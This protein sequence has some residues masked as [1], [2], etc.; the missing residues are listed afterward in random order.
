MHSMGQKTVTSSRKRAQERAQHAA[1]WVAAYS[2]ANPS[3]CLAGRMFG[4]S[5][6]AVRKAMKQLRNGNGNGNGHT[7]ALPT[8]DD[9]ADWWT[10]ASDVERAA[11]VKLVGISSVWRAIE[12]NL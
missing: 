6:P 12:S 7:S 3:V 1:R 9:A 10:T 5:P 4:V 2:D 11:L 8:F